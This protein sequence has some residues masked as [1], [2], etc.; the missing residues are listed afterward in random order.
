MA[1]TRRKTVRRKADPK[2]TDSLDVHAGKFGL[3]WKGDGAKKWAVWIVGG[4]LA[5]GFGTLILWALVSLPGRVL[6]KTQE[7]VNKGTSIERKLDDFKHETRRHNQ[8]S[9]KALKDLGEAIAGI[10]EALEDQHAAKDRGLEI[11]LAK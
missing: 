7:A 10:Q 6:G 5:L 2:P 9:D 1:P 3:V 8:R 11:G 4:L